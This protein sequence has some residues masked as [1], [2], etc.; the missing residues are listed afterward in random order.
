MTVTGCLLLFSACGGAAPAE[1]VPAKAEVPSSVPVYA[2]YSS[3]GV[4]TRHG[5]ILFFAK[6]SDPFSAASDAALRSLYDAK[7]ALVSTYRV[8]FPTSTGARLRYGV[9]VE[10]TFVLL[11]ATGERVN[12][13]VHP[14]ADDL[15]I[16]V[17]G[18]IPGSTPTK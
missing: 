7:T 2:E 9:I 12:A 16:L 18:N 17:R 15:K 8:D 5:A 13:F 14:T 1:E 3:R 10:D 4:D 11:D 6:Q